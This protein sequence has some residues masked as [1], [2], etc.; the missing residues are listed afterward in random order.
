MMKPQKQ[1]LKNMEMG[2]NF[3]NDFIGTKLQNKMY[4]TKSLKLSL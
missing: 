3:Q 1:A 2:V 4:S